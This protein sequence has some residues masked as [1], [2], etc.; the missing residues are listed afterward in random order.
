MPSLS[1][2]FSLLQGKGRLSAGH[3]ELANFGLQEPL[4]V[5]GVRFKNKPRGEGA[6]EAYRQMLVEAR[7]AT[8]RAVATGRL[9]YLP[10]DAKQEYTRITRGE[11]R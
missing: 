8:G 10:R 2:D 7:I 11:T 9:T 3:A 1:R 6:A 4:P 5:P